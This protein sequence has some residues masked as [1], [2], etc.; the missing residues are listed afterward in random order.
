MVPWFIE[1]ARFLGFWGLFLMMFFV[2]HYPEF[3]RV[4]L[5]SDDGFSR[6]FQGFACSGAVSP[7]GF[8]GFGSCFG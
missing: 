4:W 8:L 3:S 6:I 7:M 5:V 2:K 1:S